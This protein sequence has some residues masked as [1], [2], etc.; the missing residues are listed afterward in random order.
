[1]MQQQQQSTQALG[2]LLAG[3]SIMTGEEEPAT[4]NDSFYNVVTACAVDEYPLVG[5]L[6]LTYNTPWQPV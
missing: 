5:K 6:T 2:L 4:D 3:L 1:M